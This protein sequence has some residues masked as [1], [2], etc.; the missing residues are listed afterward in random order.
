MGQ[1]YNPVIEQN[2][3]KKAYDRSVNGKYMLAKLTE[4][5]WIFNPTCEYISYLLYNHPG[6]VAWIGD[7][8]EKDMCKNQAVNGETMARLIDLAWGENAN[9]EKITTMPEIDEFSISNH[10][11]I[12]NHDKKCYI[13]MKMYYGLSNQF[14]PSEEGEEPEEAGCLHPIPLLTC[15]GNGLGGGDFYENQESTNELIGAW[16]WDLIEVS[17]KLPEGYEEVRAVFRGNI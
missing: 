11:Y 14:W 16:T 1:Y 8:A 7:Y 17:D 9:L 5:S 10:K 13:D 2:N 3:V 6:R 4:H 12:L 15:V